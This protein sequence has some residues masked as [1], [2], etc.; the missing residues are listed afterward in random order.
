MKIKMTLIATIP[1]LVLALAGHAED[2]DAAPKTV[3]DAKGAIEVG[4]ITKTAN[5]TAVDPAKR[6]VTLVNPALFIAIAMIMRRQPNG[7]PSRGQA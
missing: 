1:A 5:V 6:T 2:P 3:A 4:A 7:K